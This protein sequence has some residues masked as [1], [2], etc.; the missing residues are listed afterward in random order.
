[1]GGVRTPPDPIETAPGPRPGRRRPPPLPRD[2][3]AKLATEIAVQ[4][5][6]RGGILIWLV[7]L[8]TTPLV[9]LVVWTTVARENGG[10][11]GGFTSGEYAAY[12]IAVM[13]VNNLTF[14]WIMWEME[15]RVKN[16]MFS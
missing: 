13:I 15:W 6:Y 11:A 8:V 3:G 16:G 10:S 9:S 5:A 2:Y 4:F 14:T 7:S 1:M 12:F